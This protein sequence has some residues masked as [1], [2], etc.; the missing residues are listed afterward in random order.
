MTLSYSLLSEQNANTTTA[1]IT[2]FANNPSFLALSSAEGKQILER[3]EED[4]QKLQKGIEYAKSKGVIDPNFVAEDYITVD[5]LGKSPDDVADEILGKVRAQEGEGGVVVLVG[6]SGTGKV[7]TNQENS[8]AQLSYE[9]HESESEKFCVY[10]LLRAPP[11]PSSKKN[12]K[13]KTL[14]V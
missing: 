7:S 8:M 6:L 13:H 5:V 10:L 9:R 3:D 4:A 14:S 1:I 12:S 2:H 11:W